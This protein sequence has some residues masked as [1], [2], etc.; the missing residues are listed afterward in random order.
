MIQILHS[1]KK[2]DIEWMKHALSKYLYN[3]IYKYR[4]SLL[5]VKMWV[6][7]SSKEECDDM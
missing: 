1:F 3:Y 5:G 7:F 2:N 6:F 4:V